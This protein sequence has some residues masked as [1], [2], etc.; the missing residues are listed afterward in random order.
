MKKI[1]VAGVGHGGLIAAIHLVK[2]GYDV[3]VYECQKRE[4]M[5][6]DWHDYLNL[7][8]FDMAEIERPSE[9][10]YTK[11]LTQGFRNPAK[12]R[13]I[14][15]EVGF[16]A[17][18]MDRKVLID[19]LLSYAEEVGVN[20]LYSHKVLS[21]IVE[22]NKV[23]GINV[24]D[25]EKEFAT[26]ADL[27]IDAAGLYSPV[28]SNLPKHFGIENDFEPKNIFH[29]YRAYFKNTDGSKTN[30]PYMVHLFHM[31]RPGIDWTI[32][33][34]EYVDILIGKFGAAGELTQGE[35]DDAMATLRE[36]YPFIG[37][38]IVRGGKFGDIP[39]SRMSPMIVC[40]GYA[41]VGDSAG[42]TVPLNGSGIVLSM[43]AGKILADTIIKSGGEY[44]R[45]TLWDY[46]YTYLQTLGKDYIMVDM[47]KNLFTYISGEQVN[48]FMK[49]GVVNEKTLAFGGDAFSFTPELVFNILK[50]VPFVIP[51]VP[52]LIRRLV[53]VP[54]IDVVVKMMPKKYDKE[55]VDKWIKIYKAL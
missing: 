4:E 44:T 53:G 24:S 32:T 49:T 11:G 7:T 39:L 36:E 31:N 3:T 26:K 19:Y 47:L 17:I 16:D 29:V 1:V 6:H 12:T 23:V 27:V 10:K 9:D 30:P 46:E 18:A 2:N 45:E 5:G 51:L 50:S 8:A 25:G 40:N 35:V 28:R 52:T 41:A 20:I 55:K 14:T 21:P 34:D 13:T 33:E 48:L 22:G 54:F 42:M 38:E 15:V 37:E 43:K